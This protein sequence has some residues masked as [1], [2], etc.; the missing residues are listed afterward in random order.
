M[1]SPRRARFLLGEPVRTQ[2]TFYRAAPIGFGNS[3]LSSCWNFF[4]CRVRQLG[5]WTQEIGFDNSVVPKP[6]KNSEILI[7]FIDNKRLEGAANQRRRWKRDSSNGVGRWPGW[8]EGR[9]L[10]WAE[11]RGL[12]RAKRTVG[13]AAFHLCYHSSP[14]L[15]P[16]DTL[17]VFFFYFNFSILIKK[18][19]NNSGMLVWPLSMTSL[20]IFFCFTIF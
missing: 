9:G 13:R 15:I 18:I 12:R 16:S 6:E 3:P 1:Q 14:T 11:R 10:W 20:C 8:V 4:C 19:I 2:C 5:C 7:K 17:Q